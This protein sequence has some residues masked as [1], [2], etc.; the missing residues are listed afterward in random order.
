MYRD[1][2]VVSV[3]FRDER[4]TISSVDDFFSEKEYDYLMKKSTAVFCLSKSE[5]DSNFL[6]SFK[7]KIKNNY[8]FD[9]SGAYVKINRI[10]DIKDEYDF[11]AH[12]KNLK[13]IVE[14]NSILPVFRGG[15]VLDSKVLAA[16]AVF[17]EMVKKYFNLT[18]LSDEVAF[19][20]KLMNV[21]SFGE[22]LSKTDE[23]FSE[24]NEQSKKTAQQDQT[25]KK[26][27]NSNTQKG[28]STMMKKIF[29]NTYFGA[30][31]ENV[32][33]SIYG[34]AFYN[35]TSKTFMAY[36]KN[37]STFIDVNEIVFD[38]GMYY[39]MPVA[40]AEV[41]EGDFINHTGTWEGWMRVEKTEFGIIHGINIF[42]QEVKI[43]HPKK[44][45]FG[46]DFVSKLLNPMEMMFG[47]IGPNSDNPFG[48]ILPLMLFA[49]ADKKDDKTMREMLPLM[50][51]MQNQNGGFNFNFA[52]NP[53]MMYFMMKDSGEIDPMMMM[54]MMNQNK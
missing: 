42:T 3:A 2:Y 45:I 21:N 18:N 40:A 22:T 11:E 8:G 35:D 15:E 37:T 44:N 32:K 4:K 30:V 10:I 53:L 25:S 39:I 16:P 31:K 50:F 34:P 5:K 46:F 36:D 14:I 20:T 13:E 33:M 47:G 12:K 6:N 23:E 29:G 43:V 41:K 26:L 24:T 27:I 49:D 38:F 48:N 52:E 51:M 7:F 9:Y 28:D 54:L 19:L 17:K 1:Y